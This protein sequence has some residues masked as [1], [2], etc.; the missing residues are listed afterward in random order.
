[1]SQNKKLLQF[2]SEQMNKP[3]KPKV[4][5][6]QWQH[7]GEVT[8]IPSKHITMKGVTYPVLGVDANGVAYKMQPGNNY[9][10]TKSPVTEYPMGGLTDKGF[11]Y[12][13]AW[14]G[15]FQMGGVRPSAQDGTALPRSL[16]PKYKASIQ[17]AVQRNKQGRLKSTEPFEAKDTRH[18]QSDSRAKER[19]NSYEANIALQTAIDQ[20]PYAPYALAAIAFNQGRPFT[21]LSELFKLPGGWPID[22]AINVGQENPAGVDVKTLE[23]KYIPFVRLTAGAPLFGKSIIEDIGK[24][25]VTSGEKPNSKW[26]SRQYNLPTLFEAS[27]S[28]GVDDNTFTKFIEDNWESSGGSYKK[29]LDLAKKEFSK[30]Q[31]G[32]AVPKAQEEKAVSESTALPARLDPRVKAAIEEDKKRIAFEKAIAKQPSVKS[33]N[34]PIN[35]EATKRK[36]KAYAAAKGLDYNEATGAVSA[37]FSPQTER[38]LTR[39]QENIVEPMLEL[40]GARAVSPFLKKGMQAAG[41]YTTEKAALKNANTK[42]LKDLMEELPPQLNPQNLKT[43]SGL[44]WM[45][46][47]YSH[48]DFERRFNTSLLQDDTTIDPFVTEFYKLTIKDRLSKYQPKN[49]FDLLKDKGLSEYLKY[50][51]TSGGLSYGAPENIYV[52][53]AMYA[54]FN[55]KGLESVRAHE[56]T[57]LIEHNGYLLRTQDKTALLKPFGFSN[58]SQ[59]PKD[60]GLIKQLLGEKPEYYMNPTEIHARMNQARFDLG[61]SPKDK[62]TEKM[63]DKIAK[64]KRWYGMG[65][66]IK[67]KKGFVDLMNNF[68][69]VPPAAVAASAATTEQKQQGGNIPN[70]QNGPTKSSY[71]PLVPLQRSNAYGDIQQYYPD[72]SKSLKQDQLKKYVDTQRLKN[73]STIRPSNNQGAISKAISIIANPLTAASYLAKGQRIPDNF[74]KAESNIYDIATNIV[75]PIGSIYDVSSGIGDI[76]RGDYASA[77]AN[78]AFSLTGLPSIPVYAKKAIKE[79][80]PSLHDAIKHV[81]HSN[82]ESYRHFKT[83]PEEYIESYANEKKLTKNEKGNWIEPFTGSEYTN[84]QI[85]KEIENNFSKERKL[86]SDKLKNLGFIGLMESGKIA[87]PIMTKTPGLNKIYKDLAYK[88]A[89]VS[90][91][92]QRL[93]VNHFWDVLTKYKDE[94]LKYHDKYTGVDGG[95][96]LFKRNLLKLYIY[97]DNKEFVKSKLVPRGLDKY[98]KKYGDLDVYEMF[99]DIPSGG[100]LDLAP[101]DLTTMFKGDKNNPQSFGQIIRKLKKEGFVSSP[102]EMQDNPIIPLDDIGGHMVYLTKNAPKQHSLVSQDIWKFTPD[103]YTSRWAAEHA[104]GIP[105]PLDKYLVR[106][107]STLM[108][109]AGKPFVLMQ[110]NPIRYMKQRNP[111]KNPPMIDPL[112]WD[113][114]NSGSFDD[115]KYGGEMIKRADGSYSRRGL[116]DNIRANKGSGKRP[117]KEMLAQERKIKAQE[118]QFG[119]SIPVGSYMYENPYLMNEGG[120]PDG[121]MALGQIDAAI[122]KLMNLRKFI[123][124]NSDLEPWVSSKLTIMDDYADAV[125]DYMQYNPETQEEGL[126]TMKEGGGIPDRYK[127]MGFTKTGVKKKSNR[128]GKKW[129]VLAKKGDQYKVVHGGYKGMQDYTQHNNEQRRKN[130]WSRMGGKNSSKATDPFSPLYWHKRFG[131][132]QEG[133]DVPAPIPTPYSREYL[134]ALNNEYNQFYAPPRYYGKDDGYDAFHH[135]KSQMYPTRQQDS[136]SGWITNYGDYES[137]THGSKDKPPKSKPG[138]T[139]KF[140]DHYITDYKDNMNMPFLI[141]EIMN[142]NR[143]NEIVPAY[144][145]EEYKKGGSTWS[146]NTWYKSGGYVDGDIL[147]LSPE[148]AEILKAAGYEFEIIEP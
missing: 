77:A 99:S 142:T 101:E 90:G 74:D 33:S 94:F 28:L 97:G 66:Y 22:A 75:N 67:D 18:W 43:E 79:Y 14:G 63:F 45:K 131:T 34:T 20:V 130:F 87:A 39:A 106:T 103:D 50:S 54:P 15:Q 95:E 48:P 80:D 12:N 57:H 135:F 109:Y 38:M 6:N 113:M 85:R 118:K 68:W 98:T 13:G 129:M 44:D 70:A 41:R 138:R 92:K 84:K 71:I 88:V 60:P 100:S 49:Y 117:T 1:M 82:S 126:S 51:P 7:P 24:Q 64:E 31:Q 69:A 133:G 110:E 145:R 134:A 40:E 107:Q 89:S 124:P 146:G 136:G 29:V 121:A 140:V 55:K 96:E 76:R 23:D 143:R 16:D 81:R 148:Q 112:E 32:G 102:K 137:F 86:T 46:K 108:D 37:P 8:V 5:R 132:W 61:L 10:F 78:L 111:S 65:R 73:A 144:R 122:N 27:K 17:E 59:I 2:I 125:N 105:N 3:T 83:N 25:V 35:T 147:N 123:Q 21:A 4:P 52:N 119:G 9:S 62:F 53:R 114:D 104:S 141:S 47:W 91:G 128:P 139:Y 127:N 93:D 30:K 11:N 58:E 116:W 115:Y 36:N 56:L 42:N 72:V 120:E 19:I 26:Y